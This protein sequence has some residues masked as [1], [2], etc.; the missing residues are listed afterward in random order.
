M[1]IALLDAMCLADYMAKAALQAPT[2]A[3]RPAPSKPPPGHSTR[4]CSLTPRSDGDLGL[5][6]RFR[7]VSPSLLGSIFRGEVA[8][9]FA[10]SLLSEGLRD[11]WEGRGGWRSP[12]PTGNDQSMA[13]NQIAST[14]Q[15]PAANPPA[16]MASTELCLPTAK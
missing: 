4:L 7:C 15:T 13:I 8:S 3:K 6:I 16:T 14:R 1:G 9:P 5:H 2:A 11:T 10:G 12:N